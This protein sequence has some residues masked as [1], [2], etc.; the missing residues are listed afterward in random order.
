[1]VSDS[2]SVFFYYLY[3]SITNLNMNV[4]KK[5]FVLFALCLMMSTS[6]AD[7]NKMMIVKN[8]CD[9]SE[10]LSLIAQE[11]RQDNLLP[12]EATTKLLNYLNTQ[13]L[14]EFER[15]SLT[16]MVFVIVSDAYQ[17]PVFNDQIKRNNVITGFGQHTYTSCL[18][19]LNNE[20]FKK[21]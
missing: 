8:I 19:A 20:L 2:V 1:M 11:A 3:N 10:K 5:Y 13:K 12:S 17:A 18:D 7:Q 21:K 6:Y 9:K 14:I 4:M 16:K 15:D